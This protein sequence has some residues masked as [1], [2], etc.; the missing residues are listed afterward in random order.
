MDKMT[1]RNEGIT[2][3]AIIVGLLIS[4]LIWTITVKTG[5]VNTSGI[6]IGNIGLPTGVVDTLRKLLGH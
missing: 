2:E 5:A 6:Q 4:L 3:K 1:E